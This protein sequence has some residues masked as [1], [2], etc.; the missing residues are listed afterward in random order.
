MLMK[1]LSACNDMGTVRYGCTPTKSPPT[2]R[3]E[4]EEVVREVRIETWGEGQRFPL[5]V[6]KR[7]VGRLTVVHAKPR[8]LRVVDETDKG[9]VGSGRDGLIQLPICSDRVSRIVELR[10]VDVSRVAYVEEV[11]LPRDT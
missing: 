9:L 6:D 3:S 2:Y 7:L 4:Q 8:E 5:G 11:C 10:P 1:S